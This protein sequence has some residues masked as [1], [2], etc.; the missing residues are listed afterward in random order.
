MVGLLVYKAEE[1]ML[2]L[3]HPYPPWWILG[4]VGERHFPVVGKQ[5]WDHMYPHLP[6][7]PAT[8]RTALMVLTDIIHLLIMTVIACRITQLTIAQATAEGSYGEI[9]GVRYPTYIITSEM[10]ETLL[11]VLSRKELFLLITS[12]TVNENEMNFFMTLC[13]CV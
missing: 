3:L 4:V 1:T 8:R 12:T 10:N 11:H 2:L 6:D 13:H 7:P 5:I 9:L